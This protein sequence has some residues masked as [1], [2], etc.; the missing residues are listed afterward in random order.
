VLPRHFRP[1]DEENFMPVVT[2]AVAAAAGAPMVLA[3]GA[4]G[5]TSYTVREGDTVSGIAAAHRTDVRT[6]IRANNLLGGGHRIRAGATLRVPVAGTANPAPARPQA[7][8]TGRYRV[9]AGDTIGGIALRLRVSPGTLLALN[10][11]DA[12]GRIY[13]GQH[14][15]VPARQAR[16]VVKTARS[17]SSGLRVVR[18]TVRPGDTIGGIALRLGSTQAAVL[19]ANGLSASSVIVPGRALQVPVRPRFSHNTFAGRTYAPSIVRAAEANRSALARR[20]VPGPEVTR[21]IITRVA[22]RY[23]VD[24]ALALAVGFQESSWNQRQVSPANAVGV[25]QVV[26]SSG[27]WASE[28][29]GRR[30]DLLDVEDNITAG[31][32]I[33]RSLL[34]T[35]DS[36]E[37][38]IAGYYQGLWSVRSRGMFADTKTYV[39]RIQE[40]TARLG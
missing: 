20:A 21:R 12:R 10:H 9:V 17:T 37:Q 36:R 34:R 14:L 31:V 38:A 3:A 33:L 39:R 24:P 22:T 11:L 23:G 19:K 40:L 2:T 1:A 5:W 28:L 32:V 35:A 6:L 7:A 26:P 13:A 8:R 15:V 29:V 18:Y 4:G 25:M 27:R 16:A 30:L